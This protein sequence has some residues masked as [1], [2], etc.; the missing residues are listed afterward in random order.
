MQCLEVSGAVRPIYGS[1]GVKR[2]MSGSKL[3]RRTVLPKVCLTQPSYLSVLRLRTWCALGPMLRSRGHILTAKMRL[4]LHGK[5]ICAKLSDAWA[6]PVQLGYNLYVRF[7]DCGVLAVAQVG[8]AERDNA[9]CC[10]RLDTGC[11][12]GGAI[13]VPQGSPA[14]G[15]EKRRS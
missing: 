2:L 12:C 15:A 4:C 10:R 13:G 7:S 8:V 14:Q 9:T 5:L 11:S 1:L 6:A 3:G